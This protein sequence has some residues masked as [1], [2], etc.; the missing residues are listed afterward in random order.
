MVKG[1]LEQRYYES[2]YWPDLVPIYWLYKSHGRYWLIRQKV[3]FRIASIG[4]AA[5]SISG[6]QLPVKSSLLFLFANCDILGVKIIRIDPLEPNIWLYCVYHDVSAAVFKPK[7]WSLAN[8]KRHLFFIKHG[9]YSKLLAQP[10]TT[11]TRD[12][13]GPQGAEGRHPGELRGNAR[14]GTQ[15]TQVE[16]DKK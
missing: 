15:G 7:V 11:M 9:W 8:S 14:L 16:G 13:G 1:I 4:R 3:Y 10:C 12:R 2:D 6:P 5:G